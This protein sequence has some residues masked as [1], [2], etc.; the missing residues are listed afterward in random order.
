[1]R[2]LLSNRITHPT[3]IIEVGLAAGEWRGARFVVGWVADILTKRLTVF[4]HLGAAPH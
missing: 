3:G 2:L 4:V 1:M